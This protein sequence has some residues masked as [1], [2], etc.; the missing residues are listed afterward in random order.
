MCMFC[1]SLFVLFQLTIVLFC[2]SSCTQWRGWYIERK[3]RKGYW[4]FGGKAIYYYYWYFR[5]YQFSWMNGSLPFEFVVL[6]LIILVT[7]V[8]RCALNCPVCWDKLNTRKMNTECAWDTPDKYKG[9]IFTHG[10]WVMVFNVTLKYFSAISW[11]SVLLM[12]ETRVPIENLPQ[13]I[14]KLYHIML[15]LVNPWICKNNRIYYKQ[16]LCKAIWLFK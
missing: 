1:R 15:S 7:H 9:Y 4:Y 11:W 2:P 16:Y 13:V 5:V 12:E 10:V 14:G 8:F 3:V 6:I